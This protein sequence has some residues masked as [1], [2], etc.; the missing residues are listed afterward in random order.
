MNPQDLISQVLP[1]VTLYAVLVTFGVLSFRLAKT[2]KDYERS[3]Y[4]DYLEKIKSLRD[5]FRVRK[6]EPVIAKTIQQAMETAY[7][8]SCES[9]ISITRD[10]SNQLLKAEQLSKLFT[11]GSSVKDTFEQLKKDDKA[12]DRFLGSNQGTE[13]LDEL[14]QLH[15]QRSEMSFCY[16][17]LKHYNR[18]VYISLFSMGLLFFAGLGKLVVGQIPIALLICYGYLIFS[19]F[20]ASL[21][22]AVQQH[23]AEN[24]LLTLFEKMTLYQ[25]IYNK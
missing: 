6:V 4:T 3:F 15:T 10:D 2:F 23:R 19:G 5:N 7:D 21:Y 17:R 8:K 11:D 14:D 24:R 25:D 22:G 12:Y 1:G 9:I 16:E 13:F 20:I 18:R